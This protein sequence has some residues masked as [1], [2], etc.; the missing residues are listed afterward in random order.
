MTDK[1]TLLK[2]ISN[3]R[4]QGLGYQRIAD[5]LRAEGLV[6][7]CLSTIR[8]LLKEAQNEHSSI[9]SPST[10]IQQTSTETIENV[11]DTDIKPQEEKNIKTMPNREKIKER[12]GS[13]IL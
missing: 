7:F 13:V 3:L 11:K 6:D 9:S 12:Q 1:T 5:Q 4:Y 10:N 8:R 2:R